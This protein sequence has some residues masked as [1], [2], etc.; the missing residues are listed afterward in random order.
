MENVVLT[1]KEAASVMRI[2]P[3]SMYALVRENKAPHIT[4]GKRKV[5][6]AT[7]FYEWLNDSVV[8]G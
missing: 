8:G 7:R 4:I 5:I 3:S 1:V 2:S 6:P